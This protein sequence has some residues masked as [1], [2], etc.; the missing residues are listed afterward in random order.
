MLCYEI[1]ICFSSKIVTRH[2]CPLLLSL[3]NILPPA[4]HPFIHPPPITKINF[5]TIIHLSWSF[6]PS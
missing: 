2:L 3:F 1:F 4:I 6:G 5:K